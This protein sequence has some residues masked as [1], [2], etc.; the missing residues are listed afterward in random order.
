MRREYNG[1]WTIS[2]SI[3]IHRGHHPPH[4]YLHLP[5]KIKAL[6]IIKGPYIKGEEKGFGK[7]NKEAVQ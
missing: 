6:C 7:F 1:E 2:L 5:K 4:L 3:C